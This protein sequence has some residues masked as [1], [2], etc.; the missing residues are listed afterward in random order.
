MEGREQASF[1]RKSS[2]HSDP[3][4]VCQTH[5]RHST[6]TAQTW[7]ESPPCTSFPAVVVRVVLTALSLSLSL[8]VLLSSPVQAS[9]GSVLPAP[10]DASPGSQL[11]LSSLALPCCSQI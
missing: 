1:D 5:P 6:Q 7:Y 8:C 9:P 3:H 10:L 11:T 2:H 4:P